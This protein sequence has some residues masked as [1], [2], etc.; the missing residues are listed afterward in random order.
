[1]SVVSGDSSI[2]VPLL[3]GIALSRLRRE[4]DLPLYSGKWCA[5]T[6]WSRTNAVNKGIVMRRAYNQPIRLNRER[7]WLVRRERDDDISEQ[8]ALLSLGGAETIAARLHA[9]D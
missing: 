1:M 5:I 3:T 8:D 6:Q 7:R 2:A 4:H 9:S